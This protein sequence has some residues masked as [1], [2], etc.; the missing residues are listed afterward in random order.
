MKK[1]TETTAAARARKRALIRSLIERTREAD[2]EREV[3]LPFAQNVEV[4]F[5][6]PVP[7]ME[8]RIAPENQPL[9]EVIPFPR[10]ARS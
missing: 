5:T 6:D 2:E 9:A 7:L 10:S 4:V 3:G 8:I 1:E